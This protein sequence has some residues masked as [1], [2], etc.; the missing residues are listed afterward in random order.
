MLT[1]DLTFTI[2][3]SAIK[4]TNSKVGVRGPAPGHGEHNEWLLRDVLNKSD[5]EV[6]KILGN[7]AM[8]KQNS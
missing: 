8:V 5:E 4:S 3:G 2:F 7:G 1:P 6:K